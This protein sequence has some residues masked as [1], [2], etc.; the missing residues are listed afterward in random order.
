MPNPAELRKLTG[1]AGRLGAFIAERSPLAL[2]DILEAIDA[3][4]M[5]QAPTGEAEIE[6]ARHLPARAVRAAGEVHCVR[7]ARG[8]AGVSVELRLGQAYGDLVE[9]C[10]GFF[11]RAAIQ[12]SLTTRTSR[13]CA[14]CLTRATDT[15]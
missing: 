13:C 9:T 1:L 8:V 3:C 5:A 11:R 2:P 6:L 14:E 12:A 4:G 7:A 10:D 15:V